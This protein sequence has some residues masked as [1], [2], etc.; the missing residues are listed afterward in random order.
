MIYLPGEKTEGL[1]R[2]SK[3]MSLIEPTS[4]QAALTASVPRESPVIHKII[5]YKSMSEL[6]ISWED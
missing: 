4:L 1:K 5:Q 3:I 2:I 6:R